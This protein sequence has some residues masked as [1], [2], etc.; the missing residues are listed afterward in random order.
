[1]SKY[2]RYRDALHRI[3]ENKQAMYEYI[4]REQG[5]K[6]DQN[7]RFITMYTPHK[8]TSEQQKELI[9]AVTRLYGQGVSGVD[10]VRRLGSKYNANYKDIANI[11]YRHISLK[12]KARPNPVSA[13]AQPDAP[14]QRLDPIGM[15]SSAETKHT[16][17]NV[18]M[19]VQ[20]NPRIVKIRCDCDGLRVAIDITDTDALQCVVSDLSSMLHL[21][22]E[23]R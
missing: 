20:T 13:P 5:A 3:K 19:Q 22:S 7:R 1:M 12:Q 9:E 18:V 21:I 6:N 16:M 4:V 2:T 17:P 11:I 10:M 15:Q 8:R 23:N 14:S